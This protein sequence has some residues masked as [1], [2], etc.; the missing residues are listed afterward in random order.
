[1]PYFTS[2]D[3]NAFKSFVE[4]SISL[5]PL[6]IL[7]G[8]NGS[9]K[10]S[11]IQSIRMTLSASEGN[12]PFLKGF[13]GYSDLKSNVA[14]L[15]NPIVIQLNTKS[16]DEYRLIIDKN[17]YRYSGGEIVKNA[18]YVS[19]DRLGPQTYL[20]IMSEGTVGF[21]IG[22]RGEYVADYYKYFEDII[23]NDSL[24]HASISSRKLE[25]QLMAWMGEISPG[26]KLIFDRL[27]NH[28]I[29]HL[30]VDSFRAT[31]TGFGISY[32]LPIILS[33]LVM[34]SKGPVE[35]L[36]NTRVANWIQQNIINS[37]IILIENPEAHLHPRGQTAMGELVTRA[38]ASGVQVIVETH[39][40]HFLDGIRIAIKEEKISSQD[41]NVKFF[42]KN[43]YGISEVTD[44]K[45]M[46]DGSIEN[47]PDGFFDQMY[48]NLSR[49]SM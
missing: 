36:S 48:K 44:I 18:E 30:E 49:L 19:A 20:P 34:S 32:S 7:S 25:H 37:P 5:G 17:T 2:V 15:D 46:K 8:L 9:G 1:M 47:W 40:D 4:N 31:N 22:E 10:S 21:T 16:N 26:V 38:A 28:D 13:G 33:L 42:N 3:L 24:L 23:I 27:D 12:S 11:V 43:K 45:I 35:S 14:L 41:V 6:T 39:S 29:S